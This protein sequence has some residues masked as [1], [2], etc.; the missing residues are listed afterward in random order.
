MKY[1]YKIAFNILI[2]YRRFCING[3]SVSQFQV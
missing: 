2:M 1:V 3:A